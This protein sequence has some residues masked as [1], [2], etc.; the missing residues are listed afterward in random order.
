MTAVPD[1]ERKLVGPTDGLFPPPGAVSLCIHAEMLR[2]LVVKQ[3]K[4]KYKRSILG[5]GWSLA[6]PVALMGIYLFVFGVVFENDREDFPLFLLT[7]L[8]PWQFFTLAL[9]G[10]TISLVE[11]APLVRNVSFPRFLLPLAPVVASLVNFV[12]ALGLLAVL[13]VALGRPLWLNLH[14]LLLAIVL[15]TLLVAGIVLALCVW[16]VHFRDIEQ[17]IALLTPLLFF[18]TPIVYDLSQV[19][20]EYR[21][22]VVANPLTGVMEAFHAALFDS[23]APDLWPVV[24]A[25]GETAV[26]LA[27][28]SW[29]FMRAATR[30]AKEV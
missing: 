15:E 29:I 9:L 23:S 3:L 28:G 7:G 25:A 2:A 1:T 14:W 4:L 19:P 20:S 12:V 5:F 26:V 10:G 17:L 18:A 30:L 16:D 22:F 6:T 21:P 24:V 27:L 13:V 8:L 11:N